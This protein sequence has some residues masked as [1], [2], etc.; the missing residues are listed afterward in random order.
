MLG[1][2]RNEYLEFSRPPYAADPLDAAEIIQARRRGVE[3]RILFQE[4]ALPGDGPEYLAR[5]ADAGIDVREI[6]AVPMKMA[7]M[8]GSR[9][10][11]A[12]L[13]PVLTRPAWTAVIFE[14]GGMAEAMRILF[15]DYWR[16]A[17]VPA[18]HETAR[19]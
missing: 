7:L 5:Y 12:L 1:E 2:A 9:G 15:E 11:L 10:L 8:D 16:R 6:G 18:P 19:A 14:H 13:D 3:C 17:A 4:G